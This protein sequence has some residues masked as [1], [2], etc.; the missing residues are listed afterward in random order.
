MPEMRRTDRTEENHQPRRRVE[1][2]L[3]VF[4]IFDPARRVDF[5]PRMEGRV[6][7]ESEVLRKRR[8]GRRNRRSFGGYYLRV[9]SG[10]RGSEHRDSVRF[11]CAIN[12]RTEFLN[13]LARLRGGFSLFNYPNLIIDFRRKNYVEK[14][15]EKVLQNSLKYYILL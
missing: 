1:F 7:A 4:G 5:V 2:R 8:F 14:I 3:G 13:R 6:A 10:L 15:F 12:N 9:R 11:T